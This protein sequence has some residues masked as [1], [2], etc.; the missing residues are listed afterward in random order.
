MYSTNTVSTTISGIN[1][2][3]ADKNDIE[4]I[5]VAIV[6]LE[7]IIFSSFE[8]YL[9]NNIEIPSKLYAVNIN[10]NVTSPERM[11]K[12]KAITLIEFLT[13]PLTYKKRSKRTQK[14][15]KNKCTELIVELISNKT[16]YWNRNKFNND[17][18]FVNESIKKADTTKVRLLIT[19][20]FLKIKR[21]NKFKI[22]NNKNLTFSIFN[23]AKNAPVKITKGKIVA[24]EN[25][26]TERGRLITLS[27]KLSSRTSTAAI[28]VPTI[29]GSP[30]LKDI[31]KYGNGVSTV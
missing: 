19:M 6:T 13:F 10:D 29:V 24:E 23:I 21:A 7:V 17:I 12:A 25:A 28:N 20:S 22:A 27:R 31:L 30:N 14:G 16:K 8:R 4:I 11:I 9:S 26:N 3:C 5:I 2:D 1:K 15:I 18:F